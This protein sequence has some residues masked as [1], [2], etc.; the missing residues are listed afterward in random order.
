MFGSNNNQQVINNSTVECS[1]DVCERVTTTCIN[2]QPCQV[3][4]TIIDDDRLEAELAAQ[5]E[6]DNLN[7]IEYEDDT[8]SD[9]SDEEKEKVK[10]CKYSIKD[11]NFGIILNGYDHTVFILIISLIVILVFMASV[12]RWVK[13]K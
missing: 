7:N 10:E 2:D 4:R 3:T 1:N 6:L 11:I 8:S 12:Y 13:K 5:E 9:E